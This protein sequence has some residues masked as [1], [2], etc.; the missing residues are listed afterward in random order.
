[1]TAYIGLDFGTTNSAL[2]IA[3]PEGAAQLIPLTGPQGAL[4][5]CRSILFFERGRRPS[6]LE[7]SVG[8]QAVHRYVETGGEGR[9]IQSIKSHLAS[10]LFSETLII[11]KR[12]DL[13]HLIG[14]FIRQLRGLTDMDLGDRIV[15]GRPVRYWGAKSEE[16]E[17]LALDRMREALALAGFDEVVFE[18]EPVAAALKYGSG[19]SEE[20]LVL[21]ADFGGG[22]TDFSLIRVGPGVD[23]E[24]PDSIL[25]NGGVGIGGDTFDGRIIH[26]AVAPHLGFGSEYS[27]PYGKRLPVPAWI[28]GNLER[29]HHLSF[30]RSKDTL[31][32]LREIAT[33]SEDPDQ[34]E[35]LI[36]LVD[37][38]LG[39]PLH[40]AVE[41]TKV[42]LSR[43][44]ETEFRFNLPPLDLRAAVQQ[45]AF[46]RWIQSD[47][48]EVD[49]VITDLFDRAGVS[50]DEVSRVF[51][52][53]GSSLVPSVQQMLARRF[54]AERLAGGGELTS[55]ATGLAIRARA[56][57]KGA[58]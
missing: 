37:E 44:D 26:E 21:I 28:Y 43:A 34:I 39:H 27:T 56:R 10:N 22:T 24:D 1:M 19:L 40:Q 58:A 38:N 16:E 41:R 7:V 14:L 50:P 2:A 33:G 11:N 53:G 18:Y 48:A 42:N 4:D 54:G 23:P 17:R 5:V 57:F 13:P 15:V 3:G 8:A 51:T 6:D 35:A 31:R 20:E 49:E 55:V 45:R 52:T 9:L 47:L 46:D 12:Y 25:G 36:T 32:L 29:W 30:L